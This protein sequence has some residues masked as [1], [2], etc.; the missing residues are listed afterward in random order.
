MRKYAQERAFTMSL[1]NRIKSLAH[2]QGLTLRDIETKLNLG[3]RS[4]QR[5]DTNSPAANKV[6]DVANLL[7]TSVDYLLTG[8]TSNNSCKEL[9]IGISS[10]YN[11]LSEEDK[12][13]VNSFIEIATSNL[14]NKRNNNSKDNKNIYDLNEPKTPYV[15]KKYVPI[16]GKVAAGIPITLVEEYLDKVVAPSDKAD[17]ATVANGTSMEPVIHNGENIF[18]KSM[19]SLDNGDIGVFDIDGETTCKRFKYDSTTKTVILT[20]FNSTFKPLTYPLKNYQ[21][22]FR[23]IGKVILTDEQKDRY[24]NFIQK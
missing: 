14:D 4:M 5:W 13:K 15:Y 12:I 6:L 23:I 7:H 1:L 16:L 19:Q 24:H 2:E 10:K 22:T 21:G 9:S 17:F 3:T 8:S 11:L 20:S 18:I